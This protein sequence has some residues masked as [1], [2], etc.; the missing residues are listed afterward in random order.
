MASESTDEEITTVSLPPELDR[1]L[2]ERAETLDVD[3]GAVLEQLLASY[4]ATVDLDGDG[5][6]GT[7]LAVADSETVDEVV[8]DRIETAISEAVDDRIETAI[9]EAVDDR[10]AEATSALEQQV[11]ERVD[12]L[13]A[14]YTDNL[15]DVRDRVVQ[16]KL[17]LDE[18][19]PVDHDHDQL[20]RVEELAATIEGL[21]Q[22]VD[23]LDDRL[24]E[25]IEQREADVT[26]VRESLE[27]EIE[28]VQDR[29]QTVAWVVTDLRE[30]HENN[31]S[32]DAVERIKR[33]A[34]Q[35]DIDRAKCENC[36]EGVEIAL[37]TDPEC[38][39][40]QATVTDIQAAN[41]F[42]GKPKLLVASQL[43]SGEGR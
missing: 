5:G 3:R 15:E 20:Q 26:E 18:K 41:G 31:T 19:A 43:E 16:L 10:I 27:A 13:E 39:H 12:A 37:M 9:S 38:P 25:A 22:Q 28:E 30:A 21:E 33:A 29:L 8:D 17:E 7:P 6:E 34:A 14:D 40:C 23:R 32:L 11:S 1:W 35:M 4:R 24:D 36:G 42:F 2:D